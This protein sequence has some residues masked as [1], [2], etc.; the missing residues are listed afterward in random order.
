MECPGGGGW[1]NPIERN[2]EAVLTDVI[3]GKVSLKRAKDT[4]GVVIRE[5]LTIDI[6]ATEQSRSLAN[7]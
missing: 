4:Y 3:E 5:D 6:N 7:A 2:P 1:G